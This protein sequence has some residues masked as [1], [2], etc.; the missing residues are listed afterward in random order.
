MFVGSHVELSRSTAVYSYVHKDETA[1]EGTRW[2]IGRQP[3][4][5][6]QPKDWADIL[7]SAKAGDFGTIPPDVVVRSYPNLCRIAKDHMSAQAVVKS[8]DVL[9]GK[10]GCGKF[11]CD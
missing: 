2:E 9:W 8:V 6:N 1:V 5:R 10:T 3:V 7:T 4:N 11:Y